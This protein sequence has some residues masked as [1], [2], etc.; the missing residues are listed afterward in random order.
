MGLSR[1]EFIKRTAALTAAS[2]VGISLPFSKENEAQAADADSWH[3]GTCRLCGS[4]CRLELG[5]KNGKAVALR[6][7]TKSRT[8]M[9]YLCMKGMLFY[10]LM[11]N[12][13]P[14][15]L[16]KPLYSCLLYTSPSPRD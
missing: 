4:G 6:G 3:K 7:I 16:I 8:N 15:R 10:K 14:E 11:G 12:N 1:R 9:G 5:V 2:Y 13:H